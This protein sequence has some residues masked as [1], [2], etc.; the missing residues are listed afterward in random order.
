M[1]ASHAY[2]RTCL[3]F[4]FPLWYSFQP[5]GVYSLTIGVQHGR[6][7]PLGLVLMWGV[8]AGLLQL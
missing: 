3:P 4:F 2:L 1:H 6:V 5:T 8:A 7:V